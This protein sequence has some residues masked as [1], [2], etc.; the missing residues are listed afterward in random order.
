MKSE[1]V[2]QV[3]AFNRFYTNIIG[4]LDKHILN[5]EYSLPE[6]RIM[7]ELYYNSKLTASDIIA[8]I[9]ID[10]GYLSRILKKFEKSKLIYKAES[11]TDR[12]TVFLRLSAKG[13]KE[14]EVLNQAS[15]QQIEGLL[16]TLSD[17]ECQELTQR[18]SEIQKLLNKSLKK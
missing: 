15:D 4:L 7:F 1:L 17:K 5:S 14:F 6:V 9:D 3:R 12:R 16:K 11:E 13:K 8:L 10:K 2:K 18:M